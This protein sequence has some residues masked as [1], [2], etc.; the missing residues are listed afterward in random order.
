MVEMSLVLSLA[1]TDHVIVP[2]DDRSRWRL[3]WHSSHP[4]R[5]FCRCLAKPACKEQACFSVRRPSACAPGIPRRPRPLGHGAYS[6][7]G[8]ATGNQGVPPMG[9]AA[10]S[11]ASA[12]SAP[13]NAASFRDLSPENLLLHVY[14]MHSTWTLKNGTCIAGKTPASRMGL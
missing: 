11:A 4:N 8:G 9:S 12:G 2:P 14:F 13:R 3:P 1:L 6:R 7:P 10:Q 5:S